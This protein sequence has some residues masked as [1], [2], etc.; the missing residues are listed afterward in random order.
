MCGT[1]GLRRVAVKLSA[2]RTQQD[3]V[4]EGWPGRIKVE[5]NGIDKRQ[6][7]LLKKIK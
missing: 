6:E 3:R 1:D 7:C 4:E 5:F 2:A